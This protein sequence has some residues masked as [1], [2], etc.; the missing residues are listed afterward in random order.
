MNE[1]KTLVL[2]SIG[3]TSL[4]LEKTNQLIG[5]L[6][7]KGRLTI[8]EGQELQEELTRKSSAK[9]EA[10]LGSLAKEDRKV[11]YASQADITRLE[12]KLDKLLAQNDK[13]HDE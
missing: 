6:V 2:A 3:L 9:D 8:A 1:L 5:D 4:T 7:A 12:A 10:E 11:N 13:K